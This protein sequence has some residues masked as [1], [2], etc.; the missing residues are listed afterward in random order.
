VAK[1]AAE[2]APA[3]AKQVPA[4]DP[5]PV[6]LPVANNRALALL[7]HLGVKVIK[8]RDGSFTGIFKD[9]HILTRSCR[10]TVEKT[11]SL[12]LLHHLWVLDP[13]QPFNANGERNYLDDISED[14]PEGNEAEF[15]AWLNEQLA[16]CGPKNSCSGRA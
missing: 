9:C 6:G 12:K 4:P 8:H 3:L 13:R 1:A 7:R 14:D 11:T 15:R 5:T 10:A 16:A 2:A